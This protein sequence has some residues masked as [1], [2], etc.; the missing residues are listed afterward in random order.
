ME[1]SV[2]PTLGE[3]EK[4]YEQTTKAHRNI[5]ILSIAFWLLQLPVFYLYMHKQVDFYQSMLCSGILIL[6][7][8]IKLD[9]YIKELDLFTELV[10]LV[11]NK[12]SKDEQLNKFENPYEHS[13]YPAIKN[14]Y[15]STKKHN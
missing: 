5:S 15:T 3:A 14:I 6:A 8:K 12:F 2:I 10:V 11:Q 4:I 1:M 7:I 13:K 9:D